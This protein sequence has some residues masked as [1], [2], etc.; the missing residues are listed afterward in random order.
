[1]HRA[2]LVGINA[3]RLPLT[4]MKD[5]VMTLLLISRTDPRFRIPRAVVR[6]PTD[7]GGQAE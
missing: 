1:M 7:Y 4:L 3:C 2:L 5:G 6:Q